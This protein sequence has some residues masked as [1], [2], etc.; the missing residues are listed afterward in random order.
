MNTGVQI[1]LQDSDFISFGYI[2]R[3]GLAGSQGSSIFNFLRNPHTVF[4]SGCTNLHSHQQC[5]RA[6]FSAYPR[7]HLFLVFLIIALLTGVRWYLIAVLICISLMMSDVEH[8]FTYLL[9]ICMSSFGE[10]LFRYIAHLKIIFVCFLA[11]ELYEFL[12]YVGY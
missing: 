5:T 1:S 2:P 3:S 12:I 6:T 7:Q 4:H 9:A 10:C 8:L 11:I